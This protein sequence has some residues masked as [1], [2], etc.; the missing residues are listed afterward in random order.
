M[1]KRPK[2]ILFDIDGTLLDSEELIICSYEHALS[3]IGVKKKRGELKQMMG[4]T[5][6]EAYGLL[7]PDAE[8]AQLLHTHREFT[9]GNLHMIKE[10]P[11]LEEVLQELKQRGIHMGAVTNRSPMAG[12]HIL[13]NNCLEK[14]IQVL[15]TAN[16]VAHAKPHPEP[17][18]KALDQF[19][20]PAHQALMVGDSP[21]DIQ[22]GKAAGVTTVGALYGTFG[23]LIHD[24]NPD[25]VIHNLEDLLDLV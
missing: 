4:K 20:L 8:H 5:L 16:D 14:Y 6:L 10:Y 3:C 23:E 11:K 18:L 17:V 24:H 12:I 25:H 7:V 2:V 21:A 1:N 22:A 13:G 9:Y 15:I 19:Q